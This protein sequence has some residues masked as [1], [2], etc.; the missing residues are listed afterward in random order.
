VIDLY[1]IWPIDMES[2]PLFLIVYLSSRHRARSRGRLQLADRRDVRRGEAPG[3]AVDRSCRP[4]GARVS[5]GGHAQRDGASPSDGSRRPRTSGRSRTCATA[6]RASPSAL[7]RRDRA[8]WVTGPG[9]KLVINVGGCPSDPL[10]AALH[11][12]LAAASPRT[13]RCGRRRSPSHA[14]SR[15]PSRRP[16]ISG[17]APRRLREGALVLAML[18]GGLFLMVMG[19]C[20]WPEV[21]R[22][23]G[24][25]RSSSSR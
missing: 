7:C 5:P 17:P 1:E 4:A 19:S 11:G 16:S 14:S 2:G 6:R 10:L 3:I 25:S 20:A 15:R 23:I 21:S 13:P 12:R 18:G 8:R 24:R 9:N 22:S